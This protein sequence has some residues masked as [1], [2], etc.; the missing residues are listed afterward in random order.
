MAKKNNQFVSYWS[1]QVPYGTL[2]HLA[3]GAGVGLL[4]YPYLQA[5]GLAGIIGWTLVLLGVLG[6]LYALVA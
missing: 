6:H 4:A 3:V 5:N 1:K 2:V